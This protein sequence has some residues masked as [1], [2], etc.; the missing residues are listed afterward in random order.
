MSINLTANPLTKHF[1][2]LPWTTTLKSLSW[3]PA[4]LVATHW[5][6]AVSETWARETT[7]R[8]LLAAT[9]NPSPCLTG[10]PSLYHLEE[11]IVFYSEYVCVCMCIHICLSVHMRWRSHVMTGAGVPVAWHSSSKGLLIITVLSVT[12]SAPSMKGGTGMERITSLWSFVLFPCIWLWNN[13][14]ILMCN[15]TNQHSLIFKTVK[16]RQTAFEMLN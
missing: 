9:R 12:S 6:R 2:I 1:N 10:F 7:S 14:N 3:S 15:F 4:S 11:G 5:N 16:P 8:R 13:H